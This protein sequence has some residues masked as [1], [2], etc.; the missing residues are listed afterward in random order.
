MNMKEYEKKI[1][2][3]NEKVAH[4][5]WIVFVSVI[6]SLITASLLLGLV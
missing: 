1:E 4:F 5:L 6:T 2:E 3:Q